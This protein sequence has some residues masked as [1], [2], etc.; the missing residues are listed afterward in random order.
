MHFRI[1]FKIKKAIIYVY[2]QAKQI[3]FYLST[4]GMEDNFQI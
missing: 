4:K 1:F 2:F 3:I